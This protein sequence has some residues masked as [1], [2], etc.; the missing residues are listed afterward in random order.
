M[1]L[2]V[3][4]DCPPKWPCTSDQISRHS[5]YQLQLNT[6]TM[7]P[8]WLDPPDYSSFDSNSF[9]QG[10]LTNKE[11][12]W[13]ISFLG[14]QPQ[15]NTFNNQSKHFNQKYTDLNY[16]GSILTGIDNPVSSQFHYHGL[17]LKSGYLFQEMYIFNAIMSL[18][19]F[20]KLL[21]GGGC[22]QEFHSLTLL[23]LASHLLLTQLQLGFSSFK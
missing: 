2:L 21:P 15:T 1:H 19:L 17:F 18:F 23:F 5:S 4:W 16:L 14:H 13:D 12:I 22:V 3:A 9:L 6:S 11:I 8:K 20:K 7:T 10:H